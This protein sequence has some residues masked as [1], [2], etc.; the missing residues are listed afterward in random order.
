MHVCLPVCMDTTFKPGTQEGQ[1]HVPG[2]L[3]LELEGTASCLVGSGNLF[4]VF[5]TTE[6]SLQPLTFE[7]LSTQ[8]ITGDDRSNIVQQSL[9]FTE[10]V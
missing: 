1:R 10:P 5:L 9:E 6:L 3:A 4:W 8:E 7:I 2:P